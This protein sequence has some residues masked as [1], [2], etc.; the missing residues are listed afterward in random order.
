MAKEEYTKEYSSATDFNTD[1]Y[2]HAKDN[3][4][5]VQKMYLSYTE[6]RMRHFH[7]F[8]IFFAAIILSISRIDEGWIL[9]FVSI[10]GVLVS[11]NFFLHDRGL[12]HLLISDTINELKN[13]EP[14]LRVDVIQRDAFRGRKHPFTS[15]WLYQSAYIFC[16]L[17]SAGTAVRTGYYWWYGSGQ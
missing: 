16:A 15:T 4:D 9:F 1:E 3:I 2:K 6:H 8:L 17:L 14:L 7:F 13:F 11:C 5:Y 12:S 10:I